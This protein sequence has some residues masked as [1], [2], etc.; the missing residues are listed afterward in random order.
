MPTRQNVPRIP[1][2]L[3]TMRHEAREGQVVPAR[4]DASHSSTDDKL[5]RHKL[6][7]FYQICYTNKSLS[8]VEI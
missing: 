3:N 6:G 5:D 8:E 2:S 7:I 4:P 1:R